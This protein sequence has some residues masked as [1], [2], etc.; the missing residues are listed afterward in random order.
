M[1]FDAY[2]LELWKV[3]WSEI[4]LISSDPWG[5]LKSISQLHPFTDWPH[6]AGDI[7]DKITDD[8][9]P[10]DADEVPLVQVLEVCQAQLVGVVTEVDRVDIP[11][12]LLPENRKY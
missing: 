4:T 6:F 7:T 3:E 11:S 5:K 8:D 1:Q 2:S 12:N 10:D 9:I